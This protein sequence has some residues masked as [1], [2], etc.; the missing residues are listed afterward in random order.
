[1]RQSQQS[2]AVQNWK[3]MSES[4]GV[5][6]FTSPAVT[7]PKIISIALKFAALFTWHFCGS[8]DASRPVIDFMN[9][10]T[11]SFEQEAGRQI[12]QWTVVELFI[13]WMGLE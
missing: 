1:M 7:Y 12:P 5:L 10:K 2:W 6:V 13:C 4:A 9:V 3:N 8:S 11:S